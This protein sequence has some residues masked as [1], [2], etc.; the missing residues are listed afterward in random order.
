MRFPLLLFSED[1]RFVWDLRVASQTGA[2]YT[3]R[4]PSSLPPVTICVFT[5][6]RALITAKLLLPATGNPGKLST[7]QR[8]LRHVF[9][10]QRQRG[11]RPP[12][13]A[14]PANVR[15]VNTSECISLLVI[16]GDRTELS[17][18]PRPNKTGGT[19]PPV[20]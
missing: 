3:P 14:I 19:R 9:C 10:R 12:L 5:R 4:N 17:P 20:Q 2:G 18:M 6:S 7:L 16:D 15:K 1:F 13:V 8:V 11:R